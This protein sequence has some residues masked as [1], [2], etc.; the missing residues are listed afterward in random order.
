M[1]NGKVYMA[2]RNRERAAAA[3]A[4]LETQTGRTAIFLQL[5]LSSLASVK[6]AAEEF[7][8]MER[9]LHILFNNAC[10]SAHMSLFTRPS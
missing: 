8:R 4:D 9:E 1:K 2:S 6:T 5:D 10:V 3:I 7:L